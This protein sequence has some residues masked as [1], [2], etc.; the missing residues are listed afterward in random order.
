MTNQKTKTK[1]E[2]N[3]IIADKQKLLEEKTIIKKTK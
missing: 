2:I 1:K 3:K